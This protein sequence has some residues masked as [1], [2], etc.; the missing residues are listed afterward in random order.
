[1][2]WALRRQ[3][4]YIG[5]LIV[6]FSAFG[7]LVVSP[8]LSEV[9]SCTDKKQNGDEA[10]VDCGGSCSLACNFEV[11]EI[12]VLW[13]RVFQ[14]VPGRYNAVAYLENHNQKSAISKIKYRF[15]FSDKD[16]VYIGKREGETFIPPEG[17]FAVFEVGIGVGKG[18]TFWVELDAV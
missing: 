9:P 16:N 10:G 15:R 4:F 17:K 13:S 12:S 14:V 11:D 5:I 18:S 3:L 2:S 8:R 6:F 7:F 1:M